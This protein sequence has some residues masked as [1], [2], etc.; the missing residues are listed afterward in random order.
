MG[1]SRSGGRS[2]HASEVS[3]CVNDEMVVTA[4]STYATEVNSLDDTFLKLKIQHDCM[5]AGAVR[6]V[7]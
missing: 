5:N 4:S 7:Q 3:E 2:K 6:L 1:S